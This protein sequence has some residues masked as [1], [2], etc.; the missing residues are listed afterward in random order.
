MNASVNIYMY[1]GGTNF[2]FMNGANYNLLL[3]QPI[4]TSY[5]YDA[6]LTEVGDTGTKFHILRETI[7]K[8]E[9]IPVVPIP[10]NTTKF[11]YGKVQMTRMSTFLDAVP[12]LAAPHG[13]VNPSF[14]LT[15]EQIGQNYGF[16]LYRTQIPKVFSQSSVKLTIASLM[17][18]RAIVY[19]GKVRQAT[20][21][22]RWSQSSVTLHVGLD[23]QLDIL[24][25]NTGRINAGPRMVDP[26]GIVGNVTIGGTLL[27]NWQMYPINLGNVVSE[28]PSLKF[29]SLLQ[30]GN[31]NVPTKSDDTSAPSFFHGEI[32]LSP[33]GNSVFDTFLQ[34][35]GWHKGQAFVNGVNL[36][37][38]W[39]AVGPQYTLFVP[40]N[41]LS[42][43]PSA[44]S[45]V[46]LELDGAPCLNT[47]S[48]FAEF[49]ATPSINGPVHPTGAE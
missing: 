24:V 29:S 47:T 18:D 12:E 15:M 36:G 45:V 8:H 33:H 32:P 42:L 41:V 37:R 28:L 38:Y 19:V 9:K 3:Y 13:S 4:P 14:P 48:C 11:A 16:A 5:D 27:M 7:S 39:P 35:P 21:F 40:A 17:R 30:D 2:G 20:M 10:T 43:K 25:E 22:R 46:L 49:V 34:L 23:L 44:I 31:K 6:P 26:K 1:E